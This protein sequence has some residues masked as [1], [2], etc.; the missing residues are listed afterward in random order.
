MQQNAYCLID[1]HHGHSVLWDTNLPQHKDLSVI[2]KALTVNT[3][4]V[5][6]AVTCLELWEDFDSLASSDGVIQADQLIRHLAGPSP[7]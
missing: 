4:G 1:Q 6:W 7:S 5:Y 3:T 2:S